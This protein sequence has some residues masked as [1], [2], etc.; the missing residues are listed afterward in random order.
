[1]KSIS[2]DN[3]VEELNRKFQQLETKY[4]NLREE[5]SNDNRRLRQR[6][7]ILEEEN[8]EQENKLVILHQKNHSTVTTTASI[9]ARNSN[10]SSSSFSEGDLV[11]VTNH[12]KG[13][14]GSIGKVYRITNHLVH[15]TDIKTGVSIS[16]AFKNVQKLTLSDN[17]KNNILGKQRI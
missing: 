4:N 1:M 2:I 7:A 5:Y 8:I 17:E 14:H 9:A 11:K 15:F 16:R 3:E 13:Q 6:I 10:L 12:Y